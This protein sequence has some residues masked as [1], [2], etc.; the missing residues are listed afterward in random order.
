M[1][2]N[3]AI[4]AF[5]GGGNDEEGSKPGVFGGARKR[6]SSGWGQNNA[7]VETRAEKRQRIRQD[8][9]TQCCQ[10]VT[11]VLFL[12][13]FTATV[14]L[15]RSPSSPL[16]AAHVRAMLSDGSDSL[17]AVSD[18]DSLYDYLKEVF[19]PAL[20][21]TNVDTEMAS[22]LSTSLHPI[23]AANRLLGGV[24]LRQARVKMQSDCQIGPMFSNYGISCYPPFGTDVQS[25]DSYGPN[26]R[27]V[28]SADPE[29]ITFSGKLGSYTADGFMEMLPTN[30][31]SAV[32][33]IE[34]LQSDGFIDDA[35]RAV[36]VDFSV[37]NGNVGLYATVGIAVEFGAGGGVKNAVDVI[38]MTESN[39]S[40]GG[41]GF[42]SNLMGF[43]GYVLLI[44][45][46]LWLLAEEIQEI[47]NDRWKYLKDWFWNVLDWMNLVL[48][49]V[50][51]ILRV[52]SYSHADSLNIGA[53]ELGDQNSFTNL[54]ALAEKVKTARLINAINAVFMWCKVLKYYRHM[55]LLRELIQ[56]I[57]KA[58]GL[59]VP[60]LVMFTVA[61]I[62]FCMSYNIGF[63]D[64][65][66]EFST[67]GGT[68][69]YLC[70][71]FI[72]DIE[73]MPAYDLTPAFGA[74]L[75]L[76]F[77][78]AMV[79][80]G[81]IVM[82][83]I[84]ANAQFEAKYDPNRAR[85]EMENLHED[86]PM[87]ELFRVV[88]GRIKRFLRRRV[89][90]LY[91]HL[92]KKADTEGN[93]AAAEGANGGALSPS[94]GRNSQPRATTGAWRKA[95]G[96]NGS[97]VGA[98]SL[99]NGSNGLED[100]DESQVERPDRAGLMRAIEHMSGRVLSEISILGI[101]I[102]SELHDVC[103]R[104]AQM[105]IAVEELSWRADQIHLEQAEEL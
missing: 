103:E 34:Q 85:V 14:L 32:S 98:L 102:K 2:K 73:L 60:Y 15:E 10:I 51:F 100:D 45:L 37:W 1:A 61:F 62:G 25:A 64:K 80:V 88:R 5:G 72:R 63:G 3:G 69:V 22:E 55:P 78:V 99:H 68:V 28:Y 57:Y 94:G 53:Q 21:A 75:I 101:E 12:A 91:V 87:E 56:V 93:D 17:E 31:T 76:L 38:T 82:F 36:F 48:I 66:Y 86:E 70:R 44:I 40:V 79:L 104:V 81:T 90:L 46:V 24:R 35:T 19:V 39:M 8:N 4:V 83:S 33:A 27:F 67:F 96:D 16:L 42:T 105:K 9:L 58:L 52:M 13:I 23:D 54:R 74:L 71:A 92:F 59:F 11:Y 26:S 50:A 89:P 18:A 49:I 6:W 47:I 97:R 43:V 7:V 77:Y 65:I 20:Y 41:L 95:L 29:G 84:L 30:Q